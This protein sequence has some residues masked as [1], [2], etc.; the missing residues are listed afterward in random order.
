MKAPNVA[1]P[2]AQT[3][4]NFFGRGIAGNWMRVEF[5]AR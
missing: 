1:K 4:K 5:M 3:T 2:M